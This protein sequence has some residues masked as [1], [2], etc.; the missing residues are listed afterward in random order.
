MIRPGAGLPRLIP[1]L[2]LVLLASLFH[3]HQ[4]TRNLRFHPD[5]AFFMT[6]ARAAAVKGDWLLP[7]AL[8]KPPLSLYLSALS[9]VAFGVTA[10][11]AGVLQLD[12]L[13]GEVAGR[14]PNALMAI[15]LAA[16]LMRLAGRLYGSELAALLAGLFTATSPYMLAYGA[17]AFTDMSALFWAV[18]A[19]SLLLRKHFV[20]AGLALGL[21]FW[22]KQQAVFMLPLVALLLVGLGAVRRD[23]TRFAL[24]FVLLGGAL[25]IWD[26]ARPEASLF[27]QAAA[28]NAPEQLQAAPSAWLARLRL[29]L[30]W[31]LWLLGPPLLTGCV[32]ALSIFAWI[33]SRRRDDVTR[34]AG[35]IGRVLLL[36]SALYVLAH[37]IFNFQQYDRYLLLIL[38]LL[39]LPLAGSLSGLVAGSPRRLPLAVAFAVVTVMGAGWTLTHP[40]VIGGEKGARAGIEALAAHLNSKPVATVI[41]DPWLGWELGYYLGLWHNKRRAHYPTAAAL[42]AG[43]SALDE[44]GERYLVAPLDQPH[45]DWLA[46]LAAVGFDLKLDYERDGLVVYRLAPP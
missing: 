35:A 44:T 14:L 21:A 27:V 17:G 4:V 34:R 20:W 12:P 19:L 8:D 5:E 42:A 3:F 13:L 24:A 39:I 38:P 33:R 36:F 40:G 1:R 16:M 30:E 15:V 2:L 9:M 7:G 46:A 26:A 23:W 43:A 29:W 6:F 25:V 22:S 32:L 45:A 11:E 10:D 41:Y 31:G 28:N 37:T 18:A